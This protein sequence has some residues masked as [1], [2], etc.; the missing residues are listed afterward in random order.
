MARVSASRHGDR[1]VIDAVDNGVGSAAVGRDIG[2][3][4][5][6]TMS[7]ASPQGGPTVMLVELPWP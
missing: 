7:L 2:L 6:G 3:A 5:E 4:V 1:L